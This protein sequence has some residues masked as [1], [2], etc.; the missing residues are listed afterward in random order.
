[1]L[2]FGV[3]QEIFATIRKNKLRTFLTGFSVAWGIFMLIVLLGSGNG[4]ENGIREEFK[5]DAVNSIWIYSGQTSKAFEGMQP[6]RRIQFTNE[7]Y[8]Q[9]LHKIEGIEHASARLSI[10]RNPTIAY[11][12]EYG[13]WDIVTVHPG[14]EYLEE[15]TSV[16]GRF[17]N[18][19]D[20]EK[21]RKVVAIST[22]VRDNLF[23][24]D[25]TKVLGEFINVNNVPFQ[26]VGVFTDV[27]ER[28]MRRVYLPIS[29]AQTVYNQA[30][31][32]NNLAFTTGDM[33]AEQ[34]IETT[35]MVRE[36]FAKRHK[37][38]V[39][40]KRAI[41]IRNNVEQFSQFKSLFNGIALFVWIIGV[42]TLIAGVVGVSNIM[43]ITVKERTKEIGVRKAIGATP[44]SIIGLVLLESLIIMAVAGYIGLVMG[45]GLLEFLSPKFADSGTFFKNPGVE[46]NI[47]VY[48]TVLLIV[49]GIIAGFFPALKAAKI[50][51]VIALRDE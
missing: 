13:N 40:D 14:T 38:D 23:K 11:G 27:A 47:A 4:L 48:A 2:D 22:I 42:F 30:N 17:I 50:K 9:T 41:W 28:D 34:S 3:F 31:R 19:I 45:I 43:I 12:S 32:I 18:E 51:P 16:E 15:T 37:F 20:I 36:Q 1:M 8:D 5:G 6:G 39:E 44:G 33:S 49:C 7:D 24:K 29:T 26:V 46:I 10:W 35:E 21:R 25:S